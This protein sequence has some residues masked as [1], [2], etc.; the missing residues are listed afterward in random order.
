MPAPVAFSGGRSKGGFATGRQDA[1]QA[2]AGVVAA[3]GNTTGGSNTWLDAGAPAMGTLN[4]WL[5]EIDLTGGLTEY[6]PVLA[7][8]TAG[9]SAFI[10]SIAR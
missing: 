4:Y 5:L 6:G 3:L 1:A 8:G 2:N 9:F 10:P 7:G